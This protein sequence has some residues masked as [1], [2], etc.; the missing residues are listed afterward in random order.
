MSRKS[1]AKSSQAHR[2]L[3]PFDD[4]AD[5]DIAEISFFGK[6]AILVNRSDLIQELLVDKAS[7][8]RKGPLLSVNAK[9]LLG[10]GLLTG[11]NDLNKRQRRVISP[12]FAHKKMAGYAPIVS[13]Y[14]QRRVLSWQNEEVMD[15]PAETT[16]ITLGI[17]GEMLLSANLLETSEDVGDAITTLM[18]FALDEQRAPLRAIL[19]I[20]RALPALLF[21]N[22][23][24]YQRIEERRKAKGDNGDEADLLSRLLFATDDDTG[25]PYMSD[26]LIRDET[27]TL[28]LAGLE[29]VAMSL[30]WSLFLL[31]SHPEVAQQARK[32]IDTV[33]KNRSFPELTD[34]PRLPSVLQIFKEALRLYPPAYV[35][36]RQAL[37]PVMLGSHSFKK[38][39]VF[40][41]SPYVQHRRPAHYPD[42]LKFDPDRWASPDAERR[43]PNRWAFMPF[44]GGPR[45]CIGGH[46]ALM[47]GH[48]IL[49][50]ILR[51]VDLSLPPHH[52]PVDPEPLFTLR[53]RHGL[54]LRIT[55]RHA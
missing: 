14:T 18:N 22:R 19:S 28:F 27:M 40:V 39:D 49:A 8:F 3:A 24:L 17:I 30:T 54:S 5:Q 6:Q 34:L 1:F 31:A 55:Q 7:A 50:T 10:E 43:L 46:F 51:N 20:P 26:R 45:V 21:L 11:P 44:G 13:T 32:E 29:T 9:P 12:A 53:P 47:E 15:I 38:G 23:T 25:E 35:V 2:T 48:L 37:E 36:A 41:A 33:L 42:P 4:A 52:P 16:A